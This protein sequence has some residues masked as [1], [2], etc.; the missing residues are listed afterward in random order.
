MAP[1]WRRLIGLVLDGWISQIIALGLL[2]YS[3][4]E[5]GPGVFKPLLVV[6]VMNVLLVSTVGSTIGHRICGIRVVHLANGYVGAKAGLIR[7]VLLCLGLP[8]L[9]V[10]SDGRGLHDRLAGT[11]IVRA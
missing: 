5:G 11:V 8:P 2:G 7:G 3:Y 10:D 4:G 1:F 6:L 9:I